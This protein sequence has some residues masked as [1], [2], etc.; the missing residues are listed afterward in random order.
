MSKLSQEEINRDLFDENKRLKRI[1]NNVKTYCKEESKVCNE[2]KNDDA[3]HKVDRIF[4]NGKQRAFDSL[5][6]H[7]S[8]LE[9]ES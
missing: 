9:N 1:L 7:I 8:N 4:A 5:L 2:F 6:S 3:R